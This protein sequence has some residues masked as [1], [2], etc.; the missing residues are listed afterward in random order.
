MNKIVLTP[1]TTKEEPTDVQNP[2]I[3]WSGVSDANL[4]QMEYKIDDG[5]WK[6]L[7]TGTSGSVELP[8]GTITGNG[9]HKI[10]VRAVDKAGNVK[11][12]V[13]DYYYKDNTAGFDGYLPKDGTLTLRKDYAKNLISWETDKVLNDTVY[14]RIY[15]GTEKD[16]TPSEEN[17]VCKKVFKGYWIE[18]GR[19]SCRERV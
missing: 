13:L 4:K 16:F 8:A 12:E 15:R 10:A 19:A 14:Y 11:E 18:I 7:G 3:Q 9:Q 17:M 6:K 1:A 5:A 2:T